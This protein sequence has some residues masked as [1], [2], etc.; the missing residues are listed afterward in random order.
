[1][2]RLLLVMCL[3]AVPTLANAIT[4]LALFE[5]QTYS[6][7]DPDHVSIELGNGQLKFDGPNVTATG[8]LK[9][10]IKTDRQQII[11]Y[12]EK[13]LREDYVNY[14]FPKGMS[15]SDSEERTA[16][17]ILSNGIAEYIIR[18]TL[19][20]SIAK[21]GTVIRTNSKVMAEKDKESGQYFLSIF[22]EKKYVE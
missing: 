11:Q 15:G 21:D 5:L 12:L 16:N 4:A 22:G 2:K 9:L 8:D 14:T 19:G 7:F 17:Q 10:T 6:I 13:R 1:M 20:S 18:A 3:S